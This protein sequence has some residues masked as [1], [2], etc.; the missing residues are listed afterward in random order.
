MLFQHLKDNMKDSEI[1]E[2]NNLNCS[3]HWPDETVIRSYQGYDRECKP[4][5]TEANFDF[6]IQNYSKLVDR[7]NELTE[8]INSK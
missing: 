8:I 4:S 2:L 7:V 1:E 6:L 3:W 5:F